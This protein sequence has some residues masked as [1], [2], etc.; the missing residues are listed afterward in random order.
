MHARSD[1]PELLE[2]KRL[3]LKI[4]SF[5]EFLY[6]KTRNKKRFV[7]GG[8]HGKTT[9]T[10]I[11]L[12]VLK[13]N[14]V[15]SDYLVGSLIEGFENMVGLED[16]N[17]IAVFEGD[18]YLTSP[19]DN[20]PK[21]LHYRPDVALIS[22][23]AWDHANVFPTAEIYRQQ[24]RDFLGCIEPNGSLIYC[25]DDEEV[26]D[27]VSK[28]GNLGL[29]EIPYQTHPYEVSNGIFWLKWRSEL[30]Q[31]RIFGE[32]NM[33]NISAAKEICR[34]AGLP[35]EAFYDA[36]KSF[37]GAARRQQ[38]LFSDSHLTVF[39]DFAHAPSKVRATTAAVRQLYP[40]KMLTA[41]LELHTFSSL[42]SEFLPEYR[43]TLDTATVPI[44][45]FDP[46]TIENKSLPS[47]DPEYVKTC[48]ENES[49][50]VFT[51][52][53]DLEK[54]FQDLKRDN[55]VVLLMSSGNFG[56]IDLEGL[57]QAS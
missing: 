13:H 25:R 55:S 20:R 7:I 16:G 47:L 26:N 45:Y 24:F 48:F 8:S 56:G 3:G 37:K 15:G 46:K 17:R 4:Y 9:I 28:A 29:H 18:E 5:P 19:L 52:R 32:H 53:S 10:S 54:F 21:F 42:S 33:Q 36:V 2:A 57:F 50:Q 12:H 14:N 41:C 35:D 44:V 49:L 34:A 51:S 30:V 40:E 38:C 43:G 31:T 1:N 23:I 27:L 22:G 6:E 11:V 39:L